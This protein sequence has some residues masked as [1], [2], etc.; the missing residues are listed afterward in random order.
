MVAVNFNFE[1]F[2]SVM[3]TMLASLED[4]ENFLRPVAVELAGIMHDRI[5]NKGLASDG[6]QIGEYKNSYLRMRERK[7]LGSS[8]NVIMVLTRKLSNSWVVAPTESGYGIG[9][10]DEGVAAF[11]GDNSSVTS[12][13]KMLFAEERFGKKMLDPTQDENDYAAE[14]IAEIAE[15]IIN[16]YGA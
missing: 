6:G 3:A 10:S 14:R 4:K 15:T 2:H 5:H 12:M 9:F 1:D 7:G 11:I 13:D 16:Q 8:G